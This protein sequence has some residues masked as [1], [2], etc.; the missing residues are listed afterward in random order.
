MH[1]LQ[2]NYS[3]SIPQFNF[4]RLLSTEGK[5]TFTYKCVN[6][7]GWEDQANHAMDKAIE[8]MGFNYEVLTHE[9]V[10]IR[11]IEDT[12]KVIELMKSVH[13]SLKNNLFEFCNM[14]M[15]IA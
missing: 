11:L 12:C 15:C 1:F 9:S 7:I 2:F 5:Q 6:S 8:L 3:T 13:M 10:D 14:F 4:L